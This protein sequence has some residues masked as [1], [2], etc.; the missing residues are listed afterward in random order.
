MRPRWG[1]SGRDSRGQPRDRPE[2]LCPAQRRSIAP[3]A[4]VARLLAPACRPQLSAGAV[5]VAR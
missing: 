2:G 3:R 4:G 1:G 5:D